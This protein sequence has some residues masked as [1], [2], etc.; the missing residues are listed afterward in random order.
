MKMGKRSSLGR[1]LGALLGEESVKEVEGDKVRY[2]PLSSITPNRKQPRQVFRE[3]ALAE[4]SDSIREQGILQPILVRKDPRNK[5]PG[6]ERFELIAGE[7]RFRAAGRAE[8]D[9]VPVI[10]KEMT[11]RESLEVAIL[12]NVQREDLSPLEEAE[13]YQELVDAY[14]FSHDRIAQRIGKSRMAVSN[15]LRLLNLPKEAQTMLREGRLSAGA[16][17]AL[18]PLVEKKKRLLQVAREVEKKELS[19]R[20]VEKVVR[21]ILAEL[22]KNPNKGKKKPAPG[23]RDSIVVELEKRLAGE[24]GAKVVITQRRGRGKIVL[25]YASPEELETLTERLLGS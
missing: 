5:E 17:R 4:L 10:V 8:L 14:G 13:G 23:R 22:E 1:G 12:E 15:T 16:A 18:L 6:V 24:L 21:A 19:V 25:E 9:E 20:D 11:D 3:E 7:R 2:V